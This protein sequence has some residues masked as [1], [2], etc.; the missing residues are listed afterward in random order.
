MKQNTF[1]KLFLSLRDGVHEIEVDRE[2]AAR[3]RRP[4]ERM[5]TIV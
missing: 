1:R 4:I 5:L 2:L 3:A